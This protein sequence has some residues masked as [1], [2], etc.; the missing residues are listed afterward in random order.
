MKFT[1]QDIIAVPAG[2]YP[3]EYVGAEPF[4]NE[5]GPAV[6]LAWKIQDGEHEGNEVS[7]IV[8]QKLSPKSN[9]CKFVKALKGSDIAAGEEVN[10]Q[11]YVGTR[12]MIVVEE[13]ES[14]ATRVGSFLKQQ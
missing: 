2:G 12:G 13:T 11:S 14:G 8:S 4:E 7:R 10:L 5:Y 9:L 6:K 3:A 1:M